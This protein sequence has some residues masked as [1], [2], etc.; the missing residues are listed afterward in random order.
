MN[1]LDRLKNQ[2]KEIKSKAR[3][4]QRANERINRIITIKC[5]SLAWAICLHREFGF[6]KKRFERVFHQVFRLMEDYIDR[7]DGDSLLTALQVK[8]KE[9]V[10]IEIELG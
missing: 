9:E 7:Y 3:I 6:G 5:V 10:G 8:A 2:H 1:V 4:S